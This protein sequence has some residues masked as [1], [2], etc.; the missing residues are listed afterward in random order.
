MSFF[1]FIAYAFGVIPKKLFYDL[2]SPEFC[3]WC[4]IGVQFHF[5]A[6]GYPVVS[7]PFIEKASLNCPG[8]LV[9]NQLTSFPTTN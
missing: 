7:A 5:F 9:K 4:E 8:T 6:F 2:M 3:I 1:Y